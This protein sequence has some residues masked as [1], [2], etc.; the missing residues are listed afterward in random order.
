LLSKKKV[1][2]GPKEVDVNVGGY[3][4]EFWTFNEKDILTGG[5]G[6]GL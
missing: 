5:G 3:E 2:F 6:D 4:K 1:W